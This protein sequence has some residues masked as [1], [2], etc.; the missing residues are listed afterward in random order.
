MMYGSRVL[1]VCDACAPDAEADSA[2]NEMLAPISARPIA[3]ARVVVRNEVPISNDL[4]FS[5]ARDSRAARGCAHDLT[6]YEEVLAGAPARPASRL[7]AL[8]PSAW[9]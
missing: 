7:I 9:K 4:H 3:D 6:G 5:D 1:C 8:R 2:W